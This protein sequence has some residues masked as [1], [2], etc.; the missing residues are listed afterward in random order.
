MVKKNIDIKDLPLNV[1]NL[2]TEWWNN[3]IP[4]FNIK[5]SL[6]LLQYCLS[7]NIAIFGFEGFR[8]KDNGRM[9][10]TDYIIDFSEFYKNHPKDF[11]KKSIEISKNIIESLPEKDS[12]ILFEFIL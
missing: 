6:I 11:S 10:I 12:D 8:K 4:L 1:L 7:N 5:D 2:P 3:N 9:P